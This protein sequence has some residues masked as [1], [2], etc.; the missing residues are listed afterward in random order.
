[1]ASLIDGVV[2]AARDQAHRVAAFDQQRNACAERPVRLHARVGERLA[3]NEQLGVGEAEL[4]DEFNRIRLGDAVR[5]SSREAR[6][7]QE[8]QRRCRELHDP[9]GQFDAV[10][11]L[12]R[13]HD[14]DL[15]LAIRIWGAVD[16]ERA[17]RTA[18][19]GF[20]TE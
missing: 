8:A 1:M 11:C 15:Q 2:R 6:W 19:R 20:A 16:R 17:V 10:A 5:E 9:G 7:F 18:R 4:A 13:E 14:C 3:R 12:R